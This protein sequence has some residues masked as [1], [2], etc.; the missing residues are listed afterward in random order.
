ML[1]A[2]IIEGFC[3][4]DF[5]VF[6]LPYIVYNGTFNYLVAVPILAFTQV[7]YFGNSFKVFVPISLSAV[8]T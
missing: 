3:Y 7:Y 5:S 1:I 4:D 8:W 2:A 6:N